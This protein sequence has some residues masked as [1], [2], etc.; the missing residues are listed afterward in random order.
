[1]AHRGA[2]RVTLAGLTPLE[3]GYC[4][5]VLMLAY[6]LRGI[7]GFGGVIG[8]PL[9]A[10]VMP[11]KVLVPVWTLLGMASS[12]TILGKDR[13]HVA[14]RT[15]ILFIP[16]CALGVAAGLLIFKTL[17]QHTLARLLG[18]VI[19]VYG[20]HALWRTFS[21]ARELR[22]W[23][24]AIAPAA[25]AMSGV[26]GTVFG[27]MATLTFAIYLDAH[28]LAKEAYRATISAM[29]L[30]LSVLRGAGY[31]AA[32]EFIPEAWLV[33]AAACPFMLLGIF[34][35]DRIHVRISEIVFRRIVSSTLLVSGLALLLR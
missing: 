15:F 4:A 22:R 11:I 21:P 29:L 18:A 19:T 2:A 27:A 10:L 6:G 25:A 23:P 34:I 35:G 33:F 26:I 17:D 7:S 24:A 1:M 12:V 30:T 3:L 5:C 16:W 13:K 31:I 28:R 32:G 14:V 20:A 9:L 8:M